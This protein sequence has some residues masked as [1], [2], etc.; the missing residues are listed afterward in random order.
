M[1]IESVL[2][3]DSSVAEVAVIGGQDNLTGQ[4]IHAFCTLSPNTTD[5]IDTLVEDLVLRIRS[6]I[7]PFAKPKAIYVVADLPKTRSGKI[8]RRILRKIVNNETNELGDTCSMANPNIIPHLIETV[9]LHH[10]NRHH[11]RKSNA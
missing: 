8:L 9:E 10:S 4:C 6:S 3:L 2:I 1:D 11:K 7:G 5:D